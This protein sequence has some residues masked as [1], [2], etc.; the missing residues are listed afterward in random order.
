[1]VIT[2]FAPSPTGDLHI[3]GVR[4]ALFSWLHAK[5]H[6]GE[7]KLRIEDTDRERSTEASTKVILEGMHWLGLDY[8]GEVIY[9]S[10]RFDIY[11]RIIDEMLEKGLAYHCWCS[12]EELEEMREAQ[13]AR[14][15]KPRY[16]GKYRNGGEPVEGI[17]PVVRFKNPLSGSVS[18]EDKVRGKITIDN[19]ELDDFII[20]RSDG[21]PTYNFCVVVDDA[22]QGITLVIRGEDH[23]SNTPKQIN[24]YRALNYQ[25]PEFAH[26]PM[27]LGD[28]GKRLSKRHGA[29]NVLDYQKEGYLPQAMIN[30]LVR[31]GWAHGDQEIFSMEELLKYFRIEDVH[32]AASTFNTEKLR[33]LNQHYIQKST[34]ETLAA[35]LPS[36]IQA[37]GYQLSESTLK[38]AI[39][40]YQSRAKTLKEMAENMQWIAQAPTEY[41]EAAAKKAFKGEQTIEILSELA[42]K[43]A[44]LSSYTEN[45]I[46]QAIEETV[47]HFEVGFGKVGQPARLALTG[48]APSP[49]L[50]ISFELAGQKA[51][52]ERLQN[53]VE[54]LK[55]NKEK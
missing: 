12:A 36:Y 41:P 51:S 39:P 46:H 24:L 37:I 52:V 28:D 17:N 55:T 8:Q 29:T 18:W 35:L 3:G 27:I 31:L 9:Q 5:Q 11:N 15:E 32:S 40:H 49:D 26:V 53:A 19:S 45:S 33:W 2:R 44:N 34:V 25:E 14:G 4:T 16:N 47:N 1:M 42:Q 38:A 6:Q 20:R 22:E 21:T 50:S 54:Y 7:F 30:Y 13:K 23:I 10:Q 43:L 48:G